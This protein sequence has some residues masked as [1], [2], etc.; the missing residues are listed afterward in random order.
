[1][2]KYYGIISSIGA[3]LILAGAGMRIL[4]I[5]FGNLVIILTLIAMSLYQGS[6]ISILQK[7]LKEKTEKEKAE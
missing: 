1:M 7:Q 4:D 6:V 3:L 5:P 2:V